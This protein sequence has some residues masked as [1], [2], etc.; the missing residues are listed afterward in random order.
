MFSRT[1]RRVSIILVIFILLTTSVTIFS[2]SL[3]TKAALKE[4]VQDKLISVAAIAASE[5]DGDSFTRL[6]A[7]DENSVDFI[8]IR[9][10][11]HQVKEASP[12]IRFIYTMR[13][14]GDAVEFVVDGDYGYEDEGA[15]IGTE[16][17]QAGPELL[18]GFL[19]PSAD[20][21]FTSDQWGTVLSGYSPVRDNSGA[22]VGIVGVD[23]DSS[24]VTAKM[25]R[26]NMIL[27]LVGIIAMF[28]VTLG[29]IVIERRRVIDEHNVEASEKKYRLLFERAGDSIV[30]LEA[31]GE[32]RGKIIAANTAAADLHGYSVDE[33]L[34]KSIVD[35]YPPESS[36]Y[37]SD[38][39]ERL[40]N[41]EW[42]KVE[43]LHIKKDG[44]VF[45]IEMNA[46]LLD[47]GAKKY[48]LTIERDI[49]ER[50]KAEHA[51]QQVHKKLS[52][53]NSVTFNDIQNAVFSLSGYLTLEKTNPENEIVKNYRSQEE[54]S[55]RKILNS[56]NFAKSYQDLGVNP[57]Q[58]Q[59]VNQSF[60]LGISH[61]DF[62]QI[63]RTVKLD[64]LEIYADSLLE[65]VFFTL[66]DNVL[67]HGANA[68]VVTLGYQLVRDGLLLSFEDNGKGVPDAIKEK[69]FERGYGKKQKGM[70]LFL[71]REILSITGITIRE[72]GTLGKG[73]RFEIFVPKGAYRFPEEKR[74]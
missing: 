22:V 61:L 20:K 62:S 15:V 72:T 4:S 45:P 63:N 66:A 60:I 2:L 74:E 42:L 21:E 11:L 19:G 24:T 5:I 14:H 1:P 8:R 18:A 71:V 13:I 27:Y 37:L 57:P 41:D 47:L 69:I 26:I 40:L 46:S 48:I 12:D 43:T 30:M 65:R 32:K 64:N 25:N 34:K 51:L 36:D 10:Q 3:E 16:Y 28:F 53:L 35:L 23:M 31:E 54:E 52:L 38:L 59:N 55:V 17:P 68:T 70:E 6:Q 49:T 9:D 44:T 39:V 58:W 56:L 7:G 33:I 73:A 29:I 67:H 50:K